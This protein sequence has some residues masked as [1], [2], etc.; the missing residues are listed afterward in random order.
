MQP[1]NDFNENIGDTVHYENELYRKE[2]EDE[3]TE[4]DSEDGKV[5][6]NRVC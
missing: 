1:K 5:V 4:K 2:E 6:N 3:M